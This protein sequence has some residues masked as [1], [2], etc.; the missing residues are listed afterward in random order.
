MITQNSK[1]NQGKAG[2]I[3]TEKVV[4]G[5]DSSTTACAVSNPATVAQPLDRIDPIRKRPIQAL[6]VCR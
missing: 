1:L 6:V 3:M 2:L 4:I 5:V